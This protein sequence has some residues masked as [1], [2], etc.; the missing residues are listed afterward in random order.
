MNPNEDNL[1][2]SLLDRLVDLD[3]RQ[4]HE[5]V[6]Y[7]LM[8]LREIRAL[9]VRDLERLLNSRQRILLPPSEYREVNNS[10]YVYGLRDFSAENPQNRSAMRKIRQEI[11]QTIAKFEPR[12]RNAKVQVEDA[13]DNRRS[14]NFRITGI[15]V[16]EPLSEPVAFDTFFDVKQGKYIISDH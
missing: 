3:P 2:V 1:V 8:G 7:R 16:V 10:V 9:V 14:L 12:L 5:P 4:P 6:Q 15:L 13:K 11:E